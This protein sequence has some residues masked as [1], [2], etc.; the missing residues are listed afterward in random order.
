MPLFMVIKSESDY[1]SFNT[2]YDIEHFLKYNI[3]EADTAKDAILLHVFST[4]HFSEILKIY[5][6][7]HIEQSVLETYVIEVKPGWVK[8]SPEM[9][10]DLFT[11]VENKINQSVEDAERKEYDRLK[12]KFG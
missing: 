10:N 5:D 9:F 11:A 8:S 2:S 7:K 6:L 3:V 12:K 4:I 1:E